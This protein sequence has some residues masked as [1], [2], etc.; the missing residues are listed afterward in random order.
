VVGLYFNRNLDNSED[1]LASCVTIPVFLMSYT[2]DE[3][4]VM[5]MLR[6]NETS[7]SNCCNQSNFVK[8]HGL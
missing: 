8:K 1:M 7:S 6:I 5:F 3:I 2:Y 4:R